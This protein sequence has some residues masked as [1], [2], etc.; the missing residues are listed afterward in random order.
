MAALALVVDDNESYRRLLRTVL[1]AEG[2]KVQEA[3]NGTGA[4]DLMERER[5][6]CVLSDVLMPVMDGYRLCYE[7]RSNPKISNVPCILFT[8]TYDANS[9][10][11]AMSFGADRFFVKSA[12][13]AEIMKMVREV[14]GQ[15]HKTRRVIA[16]FPT[17][18]DVM[19]K[20]SEAL[21]R[22]LEERNS[23]LMK[24]AEEL[25]RVNAEIQQFNRAAVGREERMIELKRHVNELC[26]ELGRTPPYDL[27]LFEEKK[28]ERTE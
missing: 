22:K 18:F 1:E 15:H 9:A 7:I 17:E 21:I 24:Q 16:A 19:K 4:L 14:T 5:V 25:S 12:E 2:F 10:E 20:Y 11:N 28:K 23:E 26:R 8:G 6:A 3:D 27:S 13:T